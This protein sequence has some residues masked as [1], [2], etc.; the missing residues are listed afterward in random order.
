MSE[1]PSENEEVL[2]KKKFWLIV[3]CVAIAGVVIP[4]VLGM[5]NTVFD[6]A[7]VFG[8]VAKTGQGDAE[9]VAADIS[10]SL[11]TTA[12]IW[13]V[14]VVFFVILIAALIRFFTL[15]KAEVDPPAKIR[16]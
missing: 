11:Q 3:V 5:I 14:S 15:P 12:R 4:V 7:G 13:F 10:E 16:A 9:A 6:I 1:S 2:R 8:D